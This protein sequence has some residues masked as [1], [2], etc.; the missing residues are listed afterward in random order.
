MMIEQIQL[1]HYICQAD[2]LCFRVM[3]LRLF[4]LR[5]LLI[6]V[7]KNKKGSVPFLFL[8]VFLFCFVLFCFVLI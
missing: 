6:L 2:P 4:C 1:I 5:V 3:R 8:F 7:H